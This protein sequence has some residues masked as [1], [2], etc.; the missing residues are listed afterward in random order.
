MLEKI[1]DNLLALGEIN[2][3]VS[4]IAQLIFLIFWIIIIRVSKWKY[5]TSLGLS[6]FLLFI[7]MVTQLLNITSFSRGVA[8]YA[9]ILLGVGILQIFFTKND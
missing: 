7:S 5:Q 6:L 4:L 9:F 3:F 8:E 2:N 1:I